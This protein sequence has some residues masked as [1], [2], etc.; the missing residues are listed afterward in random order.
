MKNKFKV[1][2]LIATMLILTASIANAQNRRPQNRMSYQ[3]QCLEIPGL[4]EDQKTKISAINDSHKEKIDGMRESFYNEEDIYK[5][6]EIK[7]NM[8]LEQNNHLK[9]ISKHLK[10]DQL[11][12]FNENIINGSNS[13]G[14]NFARAGR[15]GRGQGFG[16]ANRSGRGG[17]A[18]VRAPRG[19]RGGNGRW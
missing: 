11:E 5:A 4:T 14:R 6:N 10:G 2:A 19:G 3:G 12:Y 8:I 9:E 7:A 18:A 17:R 1:T 16:Q 13:R 15:A